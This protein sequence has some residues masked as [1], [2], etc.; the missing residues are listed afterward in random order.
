MPANDLAVVVAVDLFADR[1]SCNA[2]DDCADWS[3]NDRTGDDAADK[4][5]GFAVSSLGGGQESSGK[6]HDSGREQKLL[7]GIV[8]SR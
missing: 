5:G 2:A 8:L 7:H 3:T 1:V 6:S 4:T